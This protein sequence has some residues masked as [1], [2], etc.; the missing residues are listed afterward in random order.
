MAIVN[1]QCLNHIAKKVQE[2]YGDWSCLTIEEA[3]IVIDNYLTKIRPERIVLSKP[4]QRLTVIVD[5]KT[6]PELN[7]KGRD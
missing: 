1:P 7:N 2:N 3:S 5:K 6:M 4:N